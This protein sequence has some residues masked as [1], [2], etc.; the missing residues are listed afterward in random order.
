MFK[1]IEVRGD[2][3]ETITSSV[4]LP[5][6]PVQET[7]KAVVDV[8]VPEGKLKLPLV[9]HTLVPIG[10]PANEQELISLAVPKIVELP[11]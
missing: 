2:K 5:P 4:A 1:V 3:T 10:P 9:S 6:G 8:K 7:E 11:L